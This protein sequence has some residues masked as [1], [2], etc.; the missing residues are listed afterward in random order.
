MWC[1]PPRALL[2]LSDGK[3]AFLRSRSRSECLASKSSPRQQQQQQQRASGGGGGGSSSSSSERASGGGGGGSS[4]SCF[5]QP[6]HPNLGPI[7]A[8]N[9]R[10]KV[11]QLT[12]CR[13]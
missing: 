7:H 3:H 8:P 13:F 11:K 1:D 4:S 2:T 6:S 5:S 9:Q 10:R 12:A